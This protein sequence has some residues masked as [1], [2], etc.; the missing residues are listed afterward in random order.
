MSK[1]TKI[2]YEDLGSAFNNA[3]KALRFYVIG[4]LT[5]KFG[6]E[7]WSDEFRDCLYENQIELWDSDIK[8]GIDPK[9]L[10]DFGHLKPFTLK[11]RDLIKEDFGKKV[12]R[13]PTYMEEIAEVRNKWAHHQDIDS[14]EFR[15]TFGNLIIISEQLAMSDLVKELKVLRDKK[16]RIDEPSKSESIK[17]DDNSG[18]IPWFKNVTPHSDIQKGLLDESVFAANLSQVALKTARE[19][20]LN[21]ETFFSKT[22]FTAGLKSVARRVV[23][24]LNQ[25]TEAENRVISLQTGFG[26]GKT[27]SLISLYHLITLGKKANESSFTKE[28]IESTGDLLFDNA[29]IAV[30]TNTT[31]D[32]TQGRKVD[33]IHIKT[34]WGEIAYQLGGK[35]AFEIIRAN[36]ESLTAPKGL[37]RKVLE[38]TKPSLILIDELADYCVSASGRVVGGTNLSDQ[39]ISFIQELTE[40]IASIPYCVMVATLPASVDEVATSEKGT[41]ILQSLQNRLARV[42][43]DSKPVADEE[44]F[45]VV[46]RRLFEDLGDKESRR[47]V[48]NKY[49]SFYEELVFS[50]EIPRKA[51]RAEYR[52][53]LK[54]SYPFHPELIDMFRIRWASN[55]DFQRTRGVLRLLA[56]IVSDLWK[57]QGSLTGTQA[58]I[59]T[60]DVNFSNLDALTSQLKKLYGNGYDAVI[61]ADVSGSVS[62]AFQ[63]DSEKSEFKAYNITQG[64]ASTILMGSFGST[65]ANKGISIEEIKLCVL[66]PDTYN[67]NNINS[68]IDSLESNAHYLYYSSAGET[69]RYWFHTK[70]NIN[71]LINQ[72][73]SDIVNKKAEVISEILSRIEHK[74]DFITA[75]N[76]L[77]NPSDDIPE[78]QKPTLIILS[79]EYLGS[80]ND[81]N[82]RT[83]SKIKQIATKKGNTDRIYRNTI[84]FL[85]CSE[86]GY[87]KLSSDVTEYLACAKI[88]EEYQSQLE[89]DQKEDIRKKLE[90]FNKQVSSSIV[91]AYS[92][93][94][95]YSSKYSLDF[96]VL[97]QFKETIDIQINVTVL[98]LLKQEEWLL[99]AVGLG[100]LRK[101]N[102]L[103]DE[104][105][106]IKAKD[107]Y[108]AFIRYD[109][110]PMISSYRAVQES[111]LKYC[112][113]GD[114]A[115]ASGEPGK[116]NRIFYK[117]Q[118]PFFDVTSTDFWI[119]DK[120][121]YKPETEKPQKPDDEGKEGPYT[122]TEVID[123][124]ETEVEE[125]SNQEVK[126][127]NSI[128]ISGSV[129]VE[130][131]NQLFS[132]F[133]MPLAQNKIEI[134][135]S[136]KAKSTESKPLTEN[137]QEYKIVKESA[138]QLGL[139]LFEE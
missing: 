60:C 93:V 103:P 123:S 92:L 116:W 87:A 39:T 139:D 84:L 51:G 50:N 54:K 131:Y 91:S 33:G 30:F 53:I 52:E 85:V 88:R 40:S 15:R 124:P 26:G 100:T 76:V 34:I 81:I 9:D 102:L 117:E 98:E 83:K 97:R 101:N 2:Q 56:S 37:F 138:K 109:D 105:N 107:I 95:K 29:K 122:P 16:E 57:R 22:Y 67:H 21:P 62:N 110:K 12:N 4:V 120:S 31:N 66:K 137:S 112:N 69:R 86:N 132:S 106:S 71:I 3:I 44:I 134:E 13:I 136:I 115:I 23:Q 72:A 38:L 70:P 1:I 8:N 126:R 18:L 63:I 121:H 125:E 128:T 78:Q 32:P 119:V 133:V 104:T 61:S 96:I 42:G 113:N 11:F 55:H 49:M 25:Q 41:Q 73:K 127:F 20:Y 89:A 80:L 10:I 24:G 82:G 27:H 43:A 5:K 74:K 65:G 68:S 135:I 28:M 130:N 14:D 48:I 77:V 114:L 90:Q 35:E 17:V 6:S 79:P 64:V 111:L 108:E 58:L 45:E 36:D 118:V 99:D 59:Q 75:F 94:T 19:I 129:A 46:R 7:I 47:K